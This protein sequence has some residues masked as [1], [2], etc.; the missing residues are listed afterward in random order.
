MPKNL[1][2]RL[3]VLVAGSIA[4][5]LAA[6][7]FAACGSSTGPSDS[8]SNRALLVGISQYQVS[9]F[10]LSYADDDALDYFNALISGT[11]W[12]PDQV[13]ILLNSAATRDA[14]IAAINNV[15][16]QLGSDDKFVFFYSGHGTRGPDVDPLD[17]AD[18]LDEYIVPHDG[19]PNSNARDIRDDELELIFSGLPTRNILAVFDSSFSGGLIKSRMGPGGT[20]KYIDRG[21]PA[22][23]GS[24]RH[25]GLFRDLDVVRGMIT[26]TASASNESPL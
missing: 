20:I 1:L 23:A 22:D 8:G 17:E 14:I 3:S 11:N 24:G 21:I 5:I 12:S 25:D 26:Q 16:G 9:R 18:G 19:L 7:G 6:V 13:T 10:N 15:G 4:V 2:Y